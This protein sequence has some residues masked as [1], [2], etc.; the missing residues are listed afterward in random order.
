MTKQTL[1]AAAVGLA[2]SLSLA[3]TAGADV[4]D[5]FRDRIEIPTSQELADRLDFD[6]DPRVCGNPPDFVIFDDFVDEQ[7]SDLPTYPRNIEDIPN[8]RFRVPLP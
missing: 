3:P 6:C 7:L 8:I 2:L 5:D 4:G 1:I